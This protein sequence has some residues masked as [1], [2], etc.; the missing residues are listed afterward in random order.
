[1][2]TP[3]RSF[4]SEMSASQRKFLL[5][6]VA[7]VFFWPLLL[8]ALNL[9]WMLTAGALAYALSFGTNKLYSD[10]KDAAKEHLHVD[11]EERAHAAKTLF[12]Q[13]DFTGKELVVDV[14]GK[15]WQYAQLAYKTA[16]LLGMTVV[17]YVVTVG[18]FAVVKTVVPH[19]CVI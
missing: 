9:P 5:V 19:F 15:V 7:V 18:L 13:T 6:A 8:V 17:D 16:L 1:M 14:S 4:L 2:A 12:E 3:V 11:V 10:A